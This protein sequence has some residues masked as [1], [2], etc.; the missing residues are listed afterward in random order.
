LVAKLTPRVIFDVATQLAGAV[1]AGW[2]FRRMFPE[3]V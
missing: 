3:E 1:A 2:L